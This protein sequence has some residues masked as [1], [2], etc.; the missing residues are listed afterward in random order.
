M[1]TY[2]FVHFEP[3]F[4][5][6]VDVVLVMNAYKLVVDPI[7]NGT[8]AFVRIQTV[9]NVHLEFFHSGKYVDF[10]FGHWRMR[11]LICRILQNLIVQQ[12]HV[13]ATF[14]V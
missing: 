6:Q 13:H 1:I 12:A 11:M 7:V 14:P 3:R 9:F 4:P 8:Q 10:D 2:G 5:V